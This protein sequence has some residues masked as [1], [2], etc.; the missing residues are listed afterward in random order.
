MTNMY[1]PTKNTMNKHRHVFMW[2]ELIIEAV[3]DKSEVS[4]EL[5]PSQ[6]GGD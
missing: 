2:F 1:K 3:P 4:E 6:Q 5:N